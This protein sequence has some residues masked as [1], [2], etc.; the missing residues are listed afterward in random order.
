VA[1]DAPF[2]VVYDDPR[3]WSGGSF[4]RSSVCP[5][6]GLFTGVDSE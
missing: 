4:R 6:S 2:A 1:S 3:L 5:G